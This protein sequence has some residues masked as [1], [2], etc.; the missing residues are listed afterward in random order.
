MKRGRSLR[1]T[2]E[3]PARQQAGCRTARH[4]RDDAR[5]YERARENFNALL[6]QGLMQKDPAPGMYLYRVR[7]NG[8]TFLGLCCCLDV[9]DYRNN[10]IRRHEQTRYDKEEDRT[11]HIE[12]T[13]THNGP[14]VLL[15]RDTGD[16]FSFLNRLIT[17]AAV[18]DAE[19]RGEREEFT[20]SSGSR[21]PPSSPGFEQHFAASPRSTLPTGTTGQRQR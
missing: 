10:H 6:S 5:V 3:F 9:D 13:K 12:A 8:D 2:E 4:P 15:Y 7:Q 19:V 18:P 21:I 11:R 1:K 17:P 20:R 14:V 16:I